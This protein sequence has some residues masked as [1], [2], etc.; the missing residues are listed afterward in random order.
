MATPV[1]QA[2]G[3]FPGVRRSDNQTGDWDAVGQTRNPDLTDGSTADE[4]LTEL[5]PPHSFAYEL[6]N[7]TGPLRHLIAGVRGEWTF[8]PDGETTVVRWTYEFKPLP[9]RVGL[10]RLVVAPLWRLY[11]KASLQRAVRA[12]EHDVRARASV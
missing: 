12:A 6:T 10:F 1:F 7:F 8:T 9:G 3:P 2:W 5:T 11:A 4:R